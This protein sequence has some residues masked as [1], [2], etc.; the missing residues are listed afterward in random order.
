[1]SSNLY[2]TKSRFTDALSCKKK[3][4][5]STL[6]P[7]LKEP[8]SPEQL[9]RL[10]EGNRIG[11]LA[12]KLYP[13][14]VLIERGPGAAQRTG[15]A[16]AKGA[17]TVF[18]AAFSYQSM[19]I[20]A[21]ILH[22]DSVD[23]PWELIEVKAST[24]KKPAHQPDLAVQAWVLRGKGIPLSKISLLILNK[25]Y[26]GRDGE[27]LFSKEDASD[28]I[29]EAI[30]KVPD[31]VRDFMNCLKS[32]EPPETR[33]GGHCYYPYPCPFQSHCWKEVPES[34]IWNLYDVGYEKRAELFYSGILTLND[35]R[36]KEEYETPTNRQ[37]RVMRSNQPE[38]DR[39]LIKATASSWIFPY[40]YLDFET[41]SFGL[42]R[43]PGTFPYQQ[44]PMQF[45]CHIQKEK[46][47]EAE[48]FGYLH[49]KDTDPRR[50]LAVKM[51]EG[52]GPTGTILSF[53]RKFEIERIKEMA[54]GLP[55]LKEKLLVLVP[56]IEDPQELF[57]A[58][59][60]H[61]EFNGSFSLK[62]LAPVILGKEFDYSVHE[63]TSGASVQ[64]Q[65]LEMLSSSTS[66]DR[67]AAIKKNLLEYCN[68]D[69]LAMVKLV[70]WL[71]EQSDPK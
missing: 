30:K 23:S 35:P 14:G 44:V 9:A 42:P 40:Y 1:M 43:Y 54:E 15:E 59:V 58:A 6:H 49:E 11:E 48:A 41:I 52:I 27:S 21:D 33:L 8:L 34:S 3:L 57:R 66:A 67:K 65:Y 47:G 71:W 68:R 45:S 60:G 28:W 31:Q 51:L 61:P 64:T 70:D 20:V 13:D 56:R 37:I 69:T 26:A 55:D 4:Y 22:R 16:I 2:L 25:K 19:Y 7:E 5:L 50:E 46:Q 39:E 12:R 53:Y 24:K 18:E 17:L 62:V 29:E 63:I 32:P 36:L 10:E 38:I